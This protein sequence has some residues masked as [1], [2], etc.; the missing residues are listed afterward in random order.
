VNKT[1]ANESESKIANQRLEAEGQGHARRYNRHLGDAI[2]SDDLDAADSRD[3]REAPTEDPA[4]TDLAWVAKAPK[5]GAKP[6]AA[7][8]AVTRK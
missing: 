4:S 7:T 2:T 8:G 5:Q 6:A 1:E 3:A